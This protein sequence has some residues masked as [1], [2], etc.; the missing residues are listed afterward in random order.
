MNPCVSADRQDIHCFCFFFFFFGNLRVS[1]QIHSTVGDG[2]PGAP[3]HTSNFSRMSAQ[4][5]SHV[6]GCSRTQ[7]FGRLAQKHSTDIRDE[8]S[9]LDFPS[10]K[11]N[12]NIKK[13]YLGR[14]YRDGAQSVTAGPKNQRPEN[15]IGSIFAAPAQ[16][17]HFSRRVF[18]ASARKK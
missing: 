7:S 1:L 8:T 11:N 14:A 4:G 18:S 15:N 12:T 3:L 2:E 13:I 5:G 9:S 16:S 17:E 10:E 6:A